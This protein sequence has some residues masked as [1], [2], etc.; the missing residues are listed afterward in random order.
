MPTPSPGETA[1]Q[2][3]AV[4]D[5]GFTIYG[6]SDDGPDRYD[7]TVCGSVARA[8]GA[9]RAT[10]CRRVLARTFTTHISRRASARRFR[11]RRGSHWLREGNLKQTRA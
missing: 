10:A 11:L 3:M 6:I 5:A 7:V 8:R 1:G 2:I 9:D 4:T